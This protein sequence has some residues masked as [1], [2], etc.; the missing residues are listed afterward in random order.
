[1]CVFSVLVLT[2]RQFKNH[3]LD[4][5]WQAIA[6]DVLNIITFI[7]TLALLAKSPETDETKFA[8]VNGDHQNI[9]QS[10]KGQWYGAAALAAVEV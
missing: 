7:I 3:V 4:K 6:I 8:L 1:V 5:A 10:P 2:F 9:P